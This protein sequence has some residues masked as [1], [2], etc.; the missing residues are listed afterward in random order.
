MSPLA[1]HIVLR[2]LDI[3]DIADFEVYLRYDGYEAL[4]IAVT[5]RTPADIVQIVKDSG[6]RGRGGAGFPTGVKWGF[7]PKGVYP[8]Y[9]LCNCDESEPGTFNNHQIIDRNPH[10]LIEGIAISAYAIEAHTA[11]IYIRGEFAAAARRLE[12]AIAQAYERG[13]LGRNIFGKGYDL[14][15]YVHRG[16][17]AYI[18]GE[19]TAL[20]ESLEGKIGQPRLRPPFPA[21]A[22]LY[23]KPTIINNVETL[24]NVPMIVRHGAAWYRQFG[25]EKSPGTKVFSISGHVKRPGNY[26]A[27]LGIPLRELI[28]SPD[29]CQGMRS[30]RN[31]KIVVPGGAS[32]GWLTADDLDVTMDYEALAAKGSM[33]GSGGV[34]VLDESVSA[35]EVAYKMGEFFKHESCGKCT[36]CREGTYFL[37]KVLHRIMHGH[38]RKE[39]IPLLHDVY[40]QMAGNC[41]CLL[42]E[43]A[44]VPI[45]SALRLFPHEFEQVIAQAGNGR[46]DIRVM[47]V[48]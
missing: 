9:L 43:S 16:A 39:D 13:F 28:F 14:D 33:L 19:E 5:E 27:P 25:T 7:L 34:I 3:K 47:S 22:G 36:P 26:E 17:G 6:L 18:C 1:K 48:H 32:A 4:R 42:G 8:R 2:D 31:V 15:I 41:F 21:V 45:R 10:Q 23:G 37:V 24:T 38:G 29:Y 40:N 11:Y 30:D 12:R 46:R 35:V 44:V 20:M